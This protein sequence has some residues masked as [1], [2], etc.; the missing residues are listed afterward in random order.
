MSWQ[1]QVP[2]AITIL[3]NPDLQDT[4]GGRLSLVIH[5]TLDGTRRVHGKR[6]NR[7]VLAYTFQ[8]TR[9]KALELEAFIDAYYAD[10]INVT[11]HLGEVWRV[12]LVNNPFEFEATGNGERQT[13]TLEIEGTRT[14]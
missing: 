6:S 3:P 10:W 12:K 7:R 5:R 14:S 8:L 4:E 2:D 13:I 9:A 11:N 1:L